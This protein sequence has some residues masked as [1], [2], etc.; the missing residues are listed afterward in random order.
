MKKMKALLLEDIHRDVLQ[1][2]KDKG[3]SVEVL[4]C[5]LREKELRSKLRGVS[6]LG[7]RSRTLVTERAIENAD[8]LLAVG[9]FCVGTGN[10]DVSAALRQ[11]VAVF[12][13][14]YSNTRSVA[15]LII[16]EIIMLM[17]GVF[18][19]CRMLHSGVWN[20][21]GG[22]SYEIRG[23]RLGIIGYGNIGAQVGIIGE[24]LGM[25]VLYYDIL[26]KLS[27]GNAGK[28]R[29]MREVLN[30]ADVITIHV[31][32]SPRNTDLIGRKEFK[33]MKKGV[34]F[35][36]ASRGR[37]VDIAALSEAVRNGRVAG[38]AVD[39]FPNEPTASGKKFKSGLEGLS[40]MIIT[41]HIGGNTIEAQKSIARYVTDKL[42]NYVF[43]GDSFYS[44]NFPQVSLPVLKNSHRLLHV[45]RN[46][47]GV[48]SQI[49]TV[50]A[51]SGINITG[52]YLETND[53]IG[54]AITDIAREYDRS[55]IE[56]LR[57]VRE[58]IRLRVVY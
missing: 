14:P 7:V 10:V 23:K 25:K 4:P 20:K 52:Q 38:A 12:N 31:N 48:M 43:A 19:K 58:T 36:N 35:L 28:C 3:F 32:D 51:S 26:E 30:K 1:A 53:C 49:N 21:S 39:V 22:K 2:L 27:I 40:N 16:G 41:P 24:A 56:S 8:S 33:G 17:R 18:D 11:G 45:H 37:V 6:V 50:L 54:Y 57:S 34:V 13:A 42:V 47:P 46:V 55:V 44:V 29:S 5:S 15:E 9:S